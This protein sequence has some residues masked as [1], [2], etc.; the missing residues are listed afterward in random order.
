MWGQEKGKSFKLSRKGII[1][2]R[3]GTSTST[4]KPLTQKMDHPHACGDKSLI[5]FRCADYHGSSPRVWGQELQ[6][7]SLSSHTGIIPTRVGTSLCRISLQNHEEDHPHACGDKL[8]RLTQTPYAV[9]SSPRV[10]GQVKPFARSFI[11]PRIIPTRVGTS[12]IVKEL[13]FALEDHPHACG[14]KSLK[15]RT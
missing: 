1:P 3:V 10:W 15:H 12:G 8:P 13:F 4:L 14:D 2:T 11:I 7:Q 9:G 5:P 6:L